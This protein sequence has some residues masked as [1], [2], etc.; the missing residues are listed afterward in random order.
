[1]ESRITA[2]ETGATETSVSRSTMAPGAQPGRHQDA[3]LPIIRVPRSVMVIGRQPQQVLETTGIADA[4]DV[5]F[6]ETLEQGYSMVRQAQ[7]DLI[8]LWM[9]I[10]DLY[11][12]QVLSMLKLDEAT[13]QIPLV[14]YDA[15]C[16]QASA[17]SMN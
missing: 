8:V 11:A 2:R 17:A 9:P 12:C 5:V 16:L 4:F 13:C 1:M 6:V 14:T 15:C 7:P 10:D 3:P